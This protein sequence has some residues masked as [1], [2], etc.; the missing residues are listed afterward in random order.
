[1]ELVAAGWC[2]RTWLS[3]D[4][5]IRNFTFGDLGIRLVGIEL[6]VT[7]LKKKMGR[8][9]SMIL[10]P[11]ELVLFYEMDVQFKGKTMLP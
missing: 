6:G 11:Q 10:V 4:E 3:F 2:T 7:R 9:G 1:M 5:T 8:M